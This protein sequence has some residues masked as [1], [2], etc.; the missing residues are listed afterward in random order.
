MQIKNRVLSRGWYIVHPAANVHVDGAVRRALEKSITACRCE[1]R[2][3]KSRAVVD[4]EVRQR[5]SPVI[6][7]CVSM[8]G[9]ELA[10]SSKG[11]SGAMTRKSSCRADNCSRQ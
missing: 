8:A 9:V 2:L 4:V 7:R 10:R 6:Y 3:Q 11:T 1:V 5:S